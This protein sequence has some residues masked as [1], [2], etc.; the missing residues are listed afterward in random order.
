MIICTQI[1]AYIRIYVHTYVAIAYVATYVYSQV[2]LHNVN[3]VDGIP[4][5]EQ[6]T[7]ILNS[8]GM[9]IHKMYIYH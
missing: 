8:S 3:F 7:K 6:D 1:S 5:V 9:Q 4:P 2:F